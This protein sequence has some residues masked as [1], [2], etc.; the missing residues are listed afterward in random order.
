MLEVFTLRKWKQDASLVFD[1]PAKGC[2]EGVTFFA[3]A[4]TNQ[5][6]PMWERFL[7]PGL[8]TVS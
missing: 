4:F 1:L 3:H 6:K 8:H 7:I 5:V 2:K